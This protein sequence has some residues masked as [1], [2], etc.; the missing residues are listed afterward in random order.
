MPWGQCSRCR[1]RS[2]HQFAPLRRALAPEKHLAWRPQPHRPNSGR[3]GGLAHP[4]HQALGPVTCAG[5]R[6]SPPAPPDHSAAHA[7]SPRAHQHAFAYCRRHPS[8]P[9]RLLPAQDLPPLPPRCV[10]GVARAACRWEHQ[11]QGCLRYQSPPPCCCAAAGVAAAMANPAQRTCERCM[12]QHICRSRA[13]SLD[14]ESRWTPGH[15]RPLDTRPHPSGLAPGSKARGASS[16]HWSGR[17][18][19]LSMRIGRRRRG[20]RGSSLAS[21]ALGRG[22]I[23]SL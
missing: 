1:F 6:A 22:G 7:L 23:Q 17:R 8:P 2:A 14:R 9:P 20:R 10:G 11:A 21:S 13:H 19:D 3:R 18:A 12:G 15:C 5:Q 4:L 16:R